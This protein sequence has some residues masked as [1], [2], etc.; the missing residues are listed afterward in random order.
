MLQSAFKYAN[1]TVKRVVITSSTAAVVSPA[2]DNKPYVLDER[3]WNEHSIKEVETKGKD[4]AKN[5][6]YRAS[7]T[8]AERAAWQFIENHK[9]EVK[10]DLVVLNPP[11]VYGP[12]QQE[13]DKP[14]N[15][16]TSMLDWYNT[17]IKGTRTNEE[18]VNIR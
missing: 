10:F 1:D 5:D 17:V 9:G 18:L 2:P 12:V 15:L 14:E 16:N 11:F 4:A 7:K 3:S 6:M 8:L 13:V